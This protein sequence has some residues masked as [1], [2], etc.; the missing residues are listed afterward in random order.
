MLREYWQNVYADGVGSQCFG[1]RWPDK[2]SASIDRTGGESFR[3]HVRLKPEGAPR[4]YADWHDRFW[5]ETDPFYAR[6][7]YIG[8]RSDAA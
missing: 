1:T 6:K 8:G 4:R 2:R 7:R 3:I 5:W